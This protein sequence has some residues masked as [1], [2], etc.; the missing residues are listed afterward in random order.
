MEQFLSENFAI[1]QLERVPR[2][3]I[4]FV[5]SPSFRHVAL[6]GKMLSQEQTAEKRQCDIHTVTCCSSQRGELVVQGK[7]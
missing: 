6:T 1:K 7:V 2:D 5:E 3:S 4:R